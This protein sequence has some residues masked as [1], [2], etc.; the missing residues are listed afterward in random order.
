MPEEF[1]DPKQCEKAME[2]HETKMTK[3]IDKREKEIR[4][5]LDSGE[6]PPGVT[7]LIPDGST[8]VRLALG[9]AK[10]L[11]IVQTISYNNSIVV[12]NLQ[13]ARCWILLKH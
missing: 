10:S 11:K 13:E 4:A 3:F 12:R 5:R 8:K 7:G 2:E 1:E 9:W 6:M